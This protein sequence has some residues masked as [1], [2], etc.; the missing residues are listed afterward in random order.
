MDHE[1][2]LPESRLATTDEA[3][4][5]VYIHTQDVSGKWTRIR[6]AVYWFLILIYLVLPWIY[7]DGKQVI[8]LDLPGREFYIFGTTFYGHDGPLL[9]YLLLGFLFGISFITS[10]LG[11]VWC[12]YACP[13]T[14][15][16]ES[17]FKVIERFVEGSARRRENLESSPWT[18]LK[19]LKRSIKWFLYLLVSLHIVHSGLGY[20]VGTR[21]LVE[22]TLL[23]PSENFGLF[24][25]MLF[26]TGVILLDFGWFREQF[27][28]IACPYGRFQSI[29]MDENS[30]V[31]A[32]DKKRGE[33]RKRTAGIAPNDMGDCVN[34]DRCVKVCPT[35]I[36]IR[37]GL[38]MECIACTMCIDACDDIMRRV[39]KPEGLIKYTTELEVEGKKK[40]VSPRVYIY[41]VLLFGVIIGLF[42]HLQVREGLK[43]QFIRGSHVPYQ[44]IKK[45]H[46]ANMIVN[47]YKLKLNYYSLK[48]LTLELVHR[49]K[50]R[51][52]NISIIIPETPIEIQNENLEVNV[53]FQF[54]QNLLTNGERKIL[55]NLIDKNEMKIH[56]E[57]EVN[58]VGPIR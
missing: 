48:K 31:V 20:F 11:R 22:I 41:L 15:F 42:S 9:I 18:A 57:V 1:E 34:C 21:A 40:K 19:F 36:D 38:Q 23:F 2:G 39:D 53:F 32:Y 16:I 49:D 29:I 27:C 6:K 46:Q 43:S 7:I 26:L 14:V 4:L 33:P 25:T 13:Q 37:D 17:I 24:T 58:L 52:Q 30:L 3:G 51:F 55:L 12:G 54:P 28:I 45:D 35:G 5:R 47:H 50:E 8:L 10:L 56:R 44:V